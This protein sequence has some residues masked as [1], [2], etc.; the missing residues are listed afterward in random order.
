[1]TTN[2][3]ARAARQQAQAQRRQGDFD[4]AAKIL[5]QA[6]AQGLAEVADLYGVL[7]GTRREQGDFAAAAKAYDA[8]YRIE[9][10][11][12]LGG[13][14]SYNELNR[15]IVRVQLA[16][17]SLEHM[18]SPSDDLELVD[19]PRSLAHLQQRLRQQ[20]NHERRDDFWAA[21]DLAVTSALLGDASG[22]HEALDRFKAGSPPTSARA[23][24]AKTLA[25]LAQLDTA[26]RPL[27]A[28]LKAALET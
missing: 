23:A 22:A 13:A 17:E 16:P 2:L 5:G 11:P 27:L 20:I 10:D 28:A 9:T 4:A 3:D 18:V 6:I 12:T 24:Y 26:R 7:G 25:L 19:V 1:M 15:L 8:G 21:G 14:T